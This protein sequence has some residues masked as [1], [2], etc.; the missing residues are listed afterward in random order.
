MSLVDYPSS[1]DEAA[2][3][4]PRRSPCC[5]YP[6]CTTTVQPRRAH[7]YNAPNTVVRRCSKHRDRCA[8]VGCSRALIVTGAAGCRPADPGRDLMCPA[9]GGWGRC[10]NK[11]CTVVAKRGGFC[12]AHGG[13]YARCK[14]C[15]VKRAYVHKSCPDCLKLLVDRHFDTTGHNVGPH[16]TWGPKELAVWLLGA[17]APVQV[18]QSLASYTAERFITASLPDVLPHS[19]PLQPALELQ[20]RFI[21]QATPCQTPE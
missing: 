18:Q 9:H 11:H 1:D 4:R 7:Q 15:K 8:H 2:A 21:A 19:V 13:G 16:C 3:P 10:S 12:V 14:I 20:G 6:G 5:T 17:G